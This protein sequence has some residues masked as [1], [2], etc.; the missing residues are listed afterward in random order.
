MLTRHLRCLY[1]YGWPHLILLLIVF[2]LIIFLIWQVGPRRYPAG[3]YLSLLAITASSNYFCRDRIG[4]WPKNFGQVGA[5]AGFLIWFGMFSFLSSG[6][7]TAGFWRH[8]KEVA[9]GVGWAMVQQYLLNG[10]F[11]NRLAAFSGDEKNKNIPWLA[12]LMFAGAHAPN[13][14]L[15]AET[16]AGGYCFV[17]IYI[18]ERNLYLL[19]LIHLAASGLILFLAPES[20]TH[21]FRVGPGY[22]R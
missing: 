1:D 11:V 8:W 3:V 20:I 9:S 16:F 10:F 7:D 6:G 18:Q 15:M 4:F 13:W 21:G 17:K 19:T 5:F 14:F 2:I 22:F 12:A